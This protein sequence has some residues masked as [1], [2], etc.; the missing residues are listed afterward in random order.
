MRRKNRG[1]K[2]DK[3]RMTNRIK[4][5]AGRGKAK[6]Q[7]QKNKRKEEQA[8]SLEGKTQRQ[9]DIKSTGVPRRLYFPAL[10]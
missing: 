2:A 7:E 9:D 1:G 8:Q 3:L 5:E 4:A 6:R 10:Q